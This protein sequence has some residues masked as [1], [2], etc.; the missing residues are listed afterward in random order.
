[1]T[2]RPA[3]LQQA[4]ARVR[5]LGDPSLRDT[6]ERVL[7]AAA[8][9]DATQIVEILSGPEP[10]AAPE[11]WRELGRELFGEIPADGFFGDAEDLPR[12]EELGGGPEVLEFPED[13]LRPLEE[14]P[15]DLGLA[16]VNLDEP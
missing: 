7:K 2:I 13:V 8:R 11:P 1:M 3:D 10:E 15:P 16:M 14:P 12:E 9:G 6:I 4:L 5:K